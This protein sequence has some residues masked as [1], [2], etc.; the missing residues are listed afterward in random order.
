MTPGTAATTDLPARY[1]DVL[2]EPTYRVL[3][4]SRTLAVM[5]STLRIVGLS[6]LVYA[7]TGSAF[8]AAVAFGVGFLPQVIGGAL[9]GALPDRVRPRPLIVA[10]YLTEFAAAGLLGLVALPAAVSLA[11]V[12]AVATLT[13]GFT[14]ATNRL[15]AEVLPG[16][17]Y[18]L[19][20]SLSVMA[21]AAAQLSGLAFGGLVAAA[22]GPRQALLVSAGCQLV[23]AGIVRFGLADLPAPV[24]P[25]AHQVSALR[26]SW[27][28]NAALLAQRRV[29]QL[30]LIQWLPPAL[31]TGA[32]GLVIPYV[33][34][35]GFQPG[36]AGVLLAC[37]PAGMLVGELI[38]GRLIRPSVR[39]RLVAPLVV[40]AGIPLLALVLDPALPLAAALLA[41]AGG[42]FAYA[43]GL[44]RPFIDAVAEDRRGQA[45]AL[46]STGLMTVQGIGPAVLG[47]VAQLAGVRSALAVSGCACLLVAV[48]W[49]IR[50]SRSVPGS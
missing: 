11:V 48:A 27:S 17:A 7:S 25:D 41:L 33:A 24:A 40:L 1:R 28:T 14:G 39:I 12:A 6:A 32:E 19:G 8:L 20:R 44:Q 9:I 21:S 35:R 2:A 23:A 10:G 36:V 3:F 30:L 13:P 42:G 22:L 16:D 26:Q 5:A 50:W 49:R 47:G 31:I 45:F 18:V 4:V 37:V 46:L 29:R 15:V 34:L 43:L 38:V